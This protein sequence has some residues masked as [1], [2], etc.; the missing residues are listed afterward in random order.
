M[1]KIKDLTKEEL[2]AMRNS[3]YF[4]YKNMNPKNNICDDCMIRATSFALNKTYNEVKNDIIKINKKYGEGLKSNYT[5]YYYLVP[6]YADYM[7]VEPNETVHDVLTRRSNGTYIVW[8]KGDRTDHLL[9]IKNHIIYDLFNVYQ[10][11]K[12]LELYKIKRK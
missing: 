8:V 5:L 9:P 12:I 4:R 1:V 6:K 7:Y 10:K 11:N 3:K 2:D